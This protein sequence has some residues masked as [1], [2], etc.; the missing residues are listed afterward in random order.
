MRL[1]FASEGGDTWAVEVS[2]GMTLVDV[3]ALLEAEVRTFSA[4]LLLSR[5]CSSS[6]RCSV[7][8]NCYEHGALRERTRA[9]RTYIDARG[10]LTS[11][12][13]AHRARVDQ[14]CSNS[15]SRMTTCCSSSRELRLAEAGK[16]DHRG[17]LELGSFLCAHAN[18]RTALTT[19]NLH[20]NRSSA[21]L[22]CSKGC[23]RYA[24]ETGLFD[25]CR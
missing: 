11:S 2:A 13:I 15:V 25:R 10:E 24:H 8:R 22:S 6:L 12:C 3:Q 14:P 20:D 23:A 21:I 18:Q 1:I 16:L 4:L 19:S 7:W 17:E 9:E 5:S